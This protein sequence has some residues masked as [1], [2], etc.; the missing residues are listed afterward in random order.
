MYLSISVEPL[1][2]FSL[3]KRIHRVLFL[4][5]I[6]KNDIV[7]RLLTATLSFRSCSDFEELKH[8]GKG[9][10]G[11][12]IKVR[13]KL[14]GRVYAIKK[15]KLSPKFQ[16]KVL[17]EVK[18]LSRLYHKNVVRYYQA[19]IEVESTVI[20]FSSDDE[21][22]TNSFQDWIQDTIDTHP[23]ANFPSSAHYSQERPSSDES[24]TKNINKKLKSKTKPKDNYTINSISQKTQYWNVFQ[25]L[26]D[27]DNDDD[28][29]E[30]DIEAEAEDHDDDDDDDNDKS[31]NDCE[32]TTED[33]IN[34][35]DENSN[36]DHKISIEISNRHARGGYF[37]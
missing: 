19:W 30:N 12:V 36:R 9:A 13:N 4:V 15:I 33:K 34:Q 11:E 8:I 6:I 2:S 27:E 16:K 22:E 25:S 29:D 32:Q 5:V 10:F 20:A 7:F 24:F 14:D 18:T 26:E 1:L 35:D 23:N 21:R 28:I 37:S 3:L 31:K 17:T